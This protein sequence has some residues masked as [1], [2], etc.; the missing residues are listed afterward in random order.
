MRIKCKT[1]NV[2]LDS[3]TRNLETIIIIIRKSELRAT[4]FFV[5]VVVVVFVNFAFYLKPS[6]LNSIM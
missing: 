1:K 6:I 5:V 2:V 3:L 4:V